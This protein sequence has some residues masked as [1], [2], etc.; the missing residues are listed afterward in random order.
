MMNILHD[1]ETMSVTGIRELGATNATTFRNEV[2]AALPLKPKAIE[3]DL[4]QTDFVD[5]CGL[6]ALISVYK[7]AA[8]RNGGV[9]MRLMNPTPSVQQLFELT[10]MHRIFEI[11][12][13][14]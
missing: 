13:R 7:A 2:Y 1:D 6:G 4:S 14:P 8:N 12:R 3:I 11:V 10:R 5:S 9:T